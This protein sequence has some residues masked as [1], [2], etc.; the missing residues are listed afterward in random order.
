MALVCDI[1]KIR[2]A[3][4]RITFVRDG[5]P[6]ILDVCRNDY[7]KLQAQVPY[8]LFLSEQV[9]PQDEGEVPRATESLEISQFFQRAL[10]K[11]YKNLLVSQ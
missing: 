4:A 3:D 1:C 2:P 11:Y 5:K 10:K 9:I 6:R 8:G 7:A